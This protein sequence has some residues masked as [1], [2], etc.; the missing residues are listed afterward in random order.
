MKGE[1]EVF[2]DALLLLI[3]GFLSSGLIFVVVAVVP[4]LFL[5][6]CLGLV[7]HPLLRPF[8]AILIHDISKVTLLDSRFL[9]GFKPKRPWGHRKEAQHTPS[10]STSRTLACPHTSCW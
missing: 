7:L 6:V 8:A 4:F 5:L 2:V 3:F 1:T 9:T 10:S